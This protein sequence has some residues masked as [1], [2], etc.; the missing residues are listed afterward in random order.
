M[1]VFKKKNDLPEPD[2]D[3]IILK[4]TRPLECGGTDAYQQK[5]APKTIVSDE[6]T[7]FDVNSAFNTLAVDVDERLDYVCAFATPC[8]GGTFIF[9]EKRMFYREV[10]G[11]REWALLKEDLFPKLTAFVREY[12]VARSNGYHSQTHGLPENFGGSV[13]IRYASG[14][15]IS[16][17]DNQ[18]PVL[19]YD[20]GVALAG[21]F[22]QAL[23]GERAELPEASALK[24]IRYAEERADGGFTHATLTF[25]P[26]G[27][28]VNAK[29]SRYDGPQV[30]ESEKPVDAET[31]A[32]IRENIDR[33]GILAWA[34]LPESDYEYGAEKT[35][36][37]I[38]DGGEIT[39][40][41]N[42]RLPFQISNGFFNIELEMTTKH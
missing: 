23:K 14:E 4:S 11:V 27:A 39:V 34:S 40:P 38:F 3:I 19:G 33:S 1:S 13:D 25:D 17:S 5:N 2:P 30:Y 36:T 9:F 10:G 18:S 28:G 32:A 20:A 41:G 35:L 21:I 24:A 37:F 42:K 12:D 29:S 6:M 15:T 31:V 8:G 26:D 7:L 22:E 16:I